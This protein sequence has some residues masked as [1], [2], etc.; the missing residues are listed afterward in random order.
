MSYGCHIHTHSFVIQGE[1]RSKF[2][3]LACTPSPNNLVSN[4]DT[5]GPYLTHKQEIRNTC[6]IF[7]ENVKEVDDLGDLDVE[8]RI[9]L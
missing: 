4:E 3:A 5:G 9:I 8:R 2:Q 7:V 6:K 1:L